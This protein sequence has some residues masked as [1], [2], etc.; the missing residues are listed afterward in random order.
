MNDIIDPTFRI[1]RKDKSKDKLRDRNIYPEDDI[2]DPTISELNPDNLDK[3]H[4]VFFDERKG[5][6]DT[7]AKQRFSP[8]KTGGPGRTRS[9]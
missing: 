9:V 8:Y 1:Q 7:K 5:K 2:I 6:G 4:E 3:D